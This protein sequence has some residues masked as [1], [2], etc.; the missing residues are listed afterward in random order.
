MAVATGLWAAYTAS[1]IFLLSS[2]FGVA[3]IRKF[4]KKGQG[5]CGEIDVYDWAAS[6]APLAP[7][8]CTDMPWF[9]LVTA[10]ALVGTVTQALAVYALDATEIAVAGLLVYNLVSGWWPL[11]PPAFNACGLTKTSRLRP[12]AAVV[13][14]AFL[15][16]CVALVGELTEDGNS[17][18]AVAI[19]VTAA[20]GF[21]DLIIYVCRW[22]DAQPSDV[23]MD[24]R[25]L[26]ADNDEIVYGEPGSEV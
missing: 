12:Q 20:A 7:T 26:A 13:S 8:Y 23:Q 21:C 17:W 25:V 5:Q 18:A 6:R 9:Q 3:A 14:V 16:L 24:M 15:F 4:C 1:Y 10:F 22:G 11:M 19:A 2:A